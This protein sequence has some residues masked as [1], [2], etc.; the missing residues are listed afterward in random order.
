MKLK[1]NI[2]FP[3][4]AMQS[5]HVFKNYH[6]FTKKIFLRKKKAL[7]YFVSSFKKNLKWSW[8]KIDFA[9]KD[10]NNAVLCEAVL[11]SKIIF[12]TVKNDLPSS[13]LKSSLVT[14]APSLMNNTGG[15]YPCCT[16][17]RLSTG[18]FL[19]SVP[20]EEIVCNNGKVNITGPSTSYFNSPFRTCPVFTSVHLK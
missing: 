10:M 11:V 17:R 2:S 5:F 7:K 14:R 20:V 8:R 13:L 18:I 4:E 19:Q 6:D 9:A 12:L 1:F 16:C 3:L 15:C